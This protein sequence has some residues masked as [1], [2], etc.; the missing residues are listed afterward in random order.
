[1]TIS[2]NGSKRPPLNLN[3]SEK[4]ARAIAH[5]KMDR[6]R[7]LVSDRITSPPKDQYPRSG[8]GMIP[9]KVYETL[10]NDV[11]RTRELIL[12]GKLQAT[13]DTHIRDL[14][15][16]AKIF[17]RAQGARSADWFRQSASIGHPSHLLARRITE[18][19]S[20]LHLNLVNDDQV[21]ARSD[22][23]FLHDEAVTEM[24][25]NW[26][27]AFKGERVPTERGWAYLSWKSDHI[28]SLIPGAD[29]GSM[30][31]IL[32]SLAV[33]FARREDNYGLVAAWLVHDPQLA[34]ETFRELFAGYP[35]RNGAYSL[36]MGKMSSVMEAALLASDNLVLSPWHVEDEHAFER[37]G[38]L[39]PEAT[40]ESFDEDFEPAVFVR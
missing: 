15:N 12:S 20:S 18:A 14:K 40:D 34:T 37:L 11:S 23:D 4:S 2:L 3:G 5:A 28:C 6:E 24:L 17:D 19:L 16:V 8:Y 10:A 38:V 30:K 7:I 27:T 36:D 29:D 26:I 33:R 9:P 1:M 39:I 32:E 31:E 21:K 25:E 13:V 35:D 22:L